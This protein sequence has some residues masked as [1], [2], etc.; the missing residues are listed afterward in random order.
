[1][2]VPLQRLPLHAQKDW[3]VELE[4]LGYDDVWSNAAYGVDGSP[5]A[6][7]SCW[8]PESSTRL[9]RSSRPNS[10]PCDSRS[11]RGRPLAGH[12]RSIHSWHRILIADRPRAWRLDR[13]V[14][15]DRVAGGHINAIVPG[16]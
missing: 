1:M 16:I 15:I 11:K 10:R 7:A 12:A 13:L 6:L 8:A 5:L 14:R 9:R 2:G 4:A 3:F